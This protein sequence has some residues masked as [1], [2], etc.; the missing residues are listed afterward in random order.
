[1]NLKHE[2]ESDKRPP[3]YEF[4]L[5]KLLEQVSRGVVSP[6]KAYDRIIRDQKKQ[7]RSELLL[8]GMSLFVVGFIIFMLIR[9]HESL[10]MNAIYANP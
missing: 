10:V 9:Y 1:M 4:N 5:Q 2:I 8:Y 3:G 7:W 6:D